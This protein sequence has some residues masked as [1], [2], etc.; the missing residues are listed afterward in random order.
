MIS[1]TDREAVATRIEQFL[2]EHAPSRLY[3]MKPSKVESIRAQIA[4]GVY[5]TPE[6]LDAA[7]DRVLDEIL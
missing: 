5:E 7:A 4:A 3:E 2:A 1:F 6:K